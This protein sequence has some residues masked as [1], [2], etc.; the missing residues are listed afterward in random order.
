MQLDPNLSEPHVT[1]ANIDGLYNRD[2]TSAEQEF[3]LAI[4]LNPNSGYAHFM[5]A[6]YLVSLK[7]NPEWQREIQRALALDPMSSFTRTFYGWHLIYLGRY[8]QA[9][10]ELQK[11]LASQ[12]G[13]PS[14][15]MGLWGAYYKKGMKA[16]ALRAATMFFEA[17]HDQE[18][19]AALGIGY[20]Q[21]GYSEGM[22]HAA[23]VLELR[24]QR[25]HVPCI[26]IARLFAHAGD[27]SKALLWLE[28]AEQAHETPMAHLG[29]AWDWD[30]LRSEPGFQTLIR[31]MKFPAT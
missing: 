12:P 13:F 26:R 14:A 30:S 28:K 8:D 7:R 29:V 3:R 4:E 18:V 27:K 25:T 17:I 11:V 15:Y 9:I 16:E 31:R 22:E 5:Y 2:W 20:L 21:G 19:A 24:A 23:N 10:Q 1:L 6:D